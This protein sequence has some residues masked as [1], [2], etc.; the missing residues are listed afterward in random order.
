MMSK[1]V[2]MQKSNFSYDDRLKLFPVVNITVDINMFNAG[3]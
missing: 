3:S 1:R 2:V